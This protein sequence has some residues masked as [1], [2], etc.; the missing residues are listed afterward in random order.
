MGGGDGWGSGGLL[1]D[2][3]GCGIP[4][5]LVCEF[6]LVPKLKGILGLEGLGVLGKGWAGVSGWSLSSK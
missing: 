1:L 2:P 6:G 5:G 3:S 4:V